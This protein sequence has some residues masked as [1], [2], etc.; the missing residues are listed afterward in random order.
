MSEARF[1]WYRQVSG[2]NFFISVKQLL[3]AEK[4]IRCLSLLQQEALLAAAKIKSAQDD[5]DVQS[6]KSNLDSEIAWLSDFLTPIS[7][8]NVCQSDSAVAYFGLVFGRGGGLELEELE[9][10]ALGS[11]ALGSGVWG[12][13]R[14]VGVGLKLP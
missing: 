1:G 3:L 11:G 8:D 2:G 9:S 14:G 10:G 4:N 13:D 6:C 12:R 7:L 5:E